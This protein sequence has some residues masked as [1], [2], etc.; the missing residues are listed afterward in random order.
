MVTY[1]DNNYLN[2]FLNEYLH[3]MINHKKKKIGKSMDIHLNKNNIY[4]NN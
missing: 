4:K 1:L 3:S 2:F